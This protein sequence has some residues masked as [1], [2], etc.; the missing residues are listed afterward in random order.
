MEDSP[1]GRVLYAVAAVGIVVGV[2]AGAWLL[3][4][5]VGFVLIAVATWL[6]S[7]R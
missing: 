2:T 4:L 3:G 7:R 6:T 5:L 1:I